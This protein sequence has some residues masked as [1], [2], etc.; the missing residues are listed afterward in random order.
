MSGKRVPDEAS[1]PSS[2]DARVPGSGALSIVDTHPSTF[3]GERGRGCFHFTTRDKQ[4][5]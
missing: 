3:F 2:L 4:G 5:L 1:R